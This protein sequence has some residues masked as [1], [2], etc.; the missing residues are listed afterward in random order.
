MLSAK[1]I[2]KLEH[3]RRKNPVNQNHTDLVINWNKNILT[4]F[5]LI[6]ITPN[7]IN[8]FQT[9]QQTS[10]EPMIQPIFLQEKIYSYCRY[11]LCY[12]LHQCLL[13]VMQVTLHHHSMTQQQKAW[14]LKGLLFRATIH[15]IWYQTYQLI[16]IQTQVCQIILFESHLTCKKEKR[17]H[18]SKTRFDKQIKRCANL[19]SK[20][21]TTE[22]KSNAVKFKLVKDPLQLWV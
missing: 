22:N 20:L 9:T 5:T 8:L 18:R 2:L 12:T 1:I 10:D 3:F 21:L 14:H 13:M 4:C 19:I 6:Q 7:R 17:K 16:R 11:I 15:T